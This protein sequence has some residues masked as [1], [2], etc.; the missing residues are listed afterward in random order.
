[1]RLHGNITIN[2]HT[3]RKGDNV[4][5]YWIYPFFLIHMLLFGWSTFVMAYRDKPVEA[6]FLYVWG[7]ISI[8]IYVLLY[9]SIFGRDEVK[10]MFINAGLGLFGIFSQIDQML[11]VFGRKAS[12][13]PVHV[14]LIPFLYYV[15]YTFLIR[16][17]ILDITQ[18]R[19]DEKKRKFVENI[20]VVIS[21]AVY[22]LSYFLEKRLTLG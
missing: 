17:A 13:Y 14:H 6:G 4:P 15:L 18:V 5:W 7:G 10:W 20:Y 3:F 9:L 8:P 19:N 11:S 21:L 1:M 22:A 12:D 2:D 16:H